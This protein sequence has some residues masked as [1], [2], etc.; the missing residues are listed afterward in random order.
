MRPWQTSSIVDDQLN[1]YGQHLRGCAPSL[2]PPIH[3]G[4]NDGAKRSSVLS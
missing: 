4:E 3:A 1:S 2:S